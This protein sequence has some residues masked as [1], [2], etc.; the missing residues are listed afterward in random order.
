MRG[1]LRFV[2]IR[3]QRNPWWLSVC[4]FCSWQ[5]RIGAGFAKWLLR[6]RWALSVCFC[7]FTGRF[8]SGN[9]LE[10]V[11]VF[12]SGLSGAGQHC[13]G[14]QG[15]VPSA[16]CGIKTQEFTLKL[17]SHQRAQRRQCM[18]SYFRCEKGFWAAIHKTGLGARVQPFVLVALA[19]LF[20]R[21]ASD[22]SSKRKKCWS[23]HMCL[24]NPCHR[25]SAYIKPI[26][27]VK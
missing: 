7:P 27:T 3:R 6:T 26:F 18:I 22:A 1:T 4:S 12:L 14:I 5:H 23:L 21:K 10:R 11:S 15:T 9:E 24:P 2:R 25:L 17:A 13:W 16:L 19:L 20:T 8:S